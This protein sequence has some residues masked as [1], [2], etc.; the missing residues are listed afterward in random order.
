MKINS[1]EPKYIES[2]RLDQL[3]EAVN[4]STRLLVAVFAPFILTTLYFLS[5]ILSV[6]DALLFTDGQLQAP[7]LNVQIKV[8]NYFIVIPILMLIFHI[9]VLFQAANL[10]RKVTDYERAVGQIYR[11]KKLKGE[12]LGLPISIHEENQLL[13]LSIVLGVLVLPPIATLFLVLFKFIP[14]Q[15]CWISSEHLLLI[16]ID[17]WFI[18][19]LW[20]R[21]DKLFK[22]SSPEGETETAWCWLSKVWRIFID[23][24]WI[25]NAW[26]RASNVRQIFNIRRWTFKVRRIF[27]AQYCLSNRG[28]I[29]NKIL[30]VSTTLLLLVAISALITINT[31]FFPRSIESFFTLDVQRKRL[32]EHPEFEYLKPTTVCDITVDNK[33]LGLDLQ[34]R[35]FKKAKLSESFLCHAKLDGTKFQGA[36][37][38]EAQLQGAYLIEAQLQGAHL[39]NAQLQG[40]DLIEAQLQGAHLTNAQLQGANLRGTRLQEADLTNAQLQGAYLFNTQLQEADMTDAQLQGAYLF[41]TQLQEADLTNAQLQEADMTNAQL[42][43]ADLKGAQL[44]GADLIEAQLQGADLRDAQLQRADLSYAQLQGA[45][46]TNA[47]LQG[48]NL[49]NAQLQGAD[50]INAQLQG[51]DLRDAQLQGAFLMNAQFQGADL[52]DAQLQGADLRGAQL[53]GADLRGAQLQG[54]LSTFESTPF[55]TMSF[56]ERIESRQGMLSDLSGITFVGDLTEKDVNHMVETLERYVSE[57]KLEQFRSAITPHIIKPRPS[58]EEQ[59]DYFESHYSEAVTGAYTAEEAQEWITEYNKSMDEN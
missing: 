55:W 54:I 6:N 46:L 41:N 4:D 14:Y 11:G 47:Q 50:L 57:E 8:S 20:P 21:I 7:I 15:S 56:E 31:N 10:V 51:A 52:R 48:A 12:V 25:F 44:Q 49:G 59:K 26:R 24:R 13:L 19:R 23:Q 43:R 40:A 53:Q 39:T 18:H 9:Y 27:N 1:K 33:T 22:Q 3:R 35:S 2:V 34:N 45:D 28:W 17:L 5:L 58:P 32:Y 37:L 16:G 38:I 30:C 29:F 42:Q 36:Y